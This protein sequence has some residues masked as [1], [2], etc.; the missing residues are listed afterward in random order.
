MTSLYHVLIIISQKKARE[1]NISLAFNYL[2]D[3]EFVT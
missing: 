3:N 2:C 1:I